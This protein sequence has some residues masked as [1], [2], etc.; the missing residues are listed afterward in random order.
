[1]NFLDNLKRKA[2]SFS[3][4]TKQDEAKRPNQRGGM[5][6]EH[7]MSDGS[8]P[9]FQAIAETLFNLRNTIVTEIPQAEWKTLEVEVRLTLACNFIINAKIILTCITYYLGQIRDDYQR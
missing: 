4:E 5:L 3:S 9:L 2:E 8:K 1:M 7:Y 6:P